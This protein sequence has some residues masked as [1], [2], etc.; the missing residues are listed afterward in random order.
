MKHALILGA[1]SDIAKALAYK[2]AA[3]GFGVI[4]AARQSERLDNV[5]SDI[6]IRH[7]TPAQAVEFDALD[8]ASHTEFYNSLTP[9]PD[10]AI[11]VFGYLGDQQT[12]QNDF[13]EAETIINLNYTGAVSILNIIANDFERRKAGTI[14]GLSSVAGDRGRQSNYLYGSAKAGLTAY[15][16]GLRNRLAKA[17]VHVITVKPGFVRTKM[18]AG[19]PLP[20]PITA[21]PEQVAEDV[22]KAYR[23]QS[24]QVYTLW[25]WK[26]LMWVIRNIPEPIFKRLSL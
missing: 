25:M 20:G 7:N 5:I 14:V 22:F 15:L 8:Y 3:Q 26:Y 12:A 13:A 16:S 10:V 17:N 2:F 21:K 9:K 6:E 24:N 23:R 11:C 19:K 1:T 4:L 18:T